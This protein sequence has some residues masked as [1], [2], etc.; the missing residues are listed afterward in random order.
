MRP[1]IGAIAA[2]GL[3]YALAVVIVTPDYLTRIVPLIADSFWGFNEDAST[4]LGRARFDLLGL[5]VTL[6]F[7]ALVGMVWVCDGVNLLDRAGRRILAKSALND[8]VIVSLW[9]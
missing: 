7:C 3:L 5:A 1:E 4:V 2:T 8:D 9:R 6:A